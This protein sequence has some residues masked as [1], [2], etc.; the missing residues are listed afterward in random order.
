MYEEDHYKILRD[1]YNHIIEEFDMIK[2]IVET[3]NEYDH[4][5]ID[6]IKETDDRIIKVINKYRY[7]I[8]IIVDYYVLI[9]IFRK[10]YY[11]DHIIFLVGEKHAETIKGRLQMMNIF[12]GPVKYA[13]QHSQTQHSQHSQHSHTSSSKQRM[14]VKRGKNIKYISLNG[15]FY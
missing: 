11:A 5:E 6:H 2:D 7:A 8:S 4:I 3:I 14:P 13:Y 15:S 12:N 10:D 1:F 9:Q